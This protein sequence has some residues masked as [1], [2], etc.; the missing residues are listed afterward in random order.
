VLPPSLSGQPAASS[1]LD[2]PAAAAPPPPPPSSPRT[3]G[4]DAWRL[5]RTP[6]PHCRKGPSVFRCGAT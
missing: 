1:A 2:P 3:C 4:A 5:Y 6:P